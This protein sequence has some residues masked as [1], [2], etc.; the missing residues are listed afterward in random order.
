MQ[1]S[2][3]ICVNYTLVEKFMREVLIKL[4]VQL[5]DFKTF[6]HKVLQ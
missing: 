4:I 2:S 5:Y 3:H 1:L 6:I